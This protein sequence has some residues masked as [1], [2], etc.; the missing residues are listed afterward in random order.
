MQFKGSETGWRVL[1]EWSRDLEGYDEAVNR[2]R[3]DAGFSHQRGKQAVTSMRNLVFEA[4]DAGATFAPETLAAWG[5]GRKQPEPGGTVRPAKQT[6]TGEEIM[7]RYKPNPDGDVIGVALPIGVVMLSGGGGLGKS[8]LAAT[9]SAHV[10]TGEPCQPWEVAKP[11]NS[12]KPADVLWLTVEEDVREIVVP[13]HKEIGGNLSRLHLEK[14]TPTEWG[15]DNTPVASDFDIEVDLLPLL[16]NAKARGAPIRLVVC[17]TLTALVNWHR[18]KRS[19]NSD[20]DVK[21]VLGNLKK[22]AT[23][24]GVCILGTHHLNKKADD[25]VETRMTGAGA[26]R[27]FPRL[28]FMC[29]APNNDGTGTCFLR[30][31]KG[32]DLDGYYGVTYE[33]EEVRLLRLVEAETEDGKPIRKALRRVKFTSKLLKSAD[34]VDRLRLAQ[35]GIADERAEAKRTDRH[36]DMAAI[37]RDLFEMCGADEMAARVVWREV[38]RKKE[39]GGYGRMPNSEEKTRVCELAGVRG[40]RGKQ[41]LW[42][43]E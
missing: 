14:V 39:R 40:G 6:E 42:R 4:R 28:A 29:E 32:N 41:T 23:E 9:W 38:A 22:I 16:A 17:D 31:I 3:W 43:V 27:D 5:L 15:K 20:A 13:R 33:Q 36:E 12:R 37:V 26:W 7:Q 18:D 35:Q 10:T 8:T 2:K 11:K 30:M 19:G 1:D 34:V 24:F 25:P 21:Q